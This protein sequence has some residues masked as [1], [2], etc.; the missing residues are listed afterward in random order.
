MI[1]YSALPD[2][3][4]STIT[5]LFNGTTQGSAFT[6]PCQRSTI[7]ATLTPQDGNAP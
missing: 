6:M 5:F 3:P 2:I 1:T 7:A 4:L